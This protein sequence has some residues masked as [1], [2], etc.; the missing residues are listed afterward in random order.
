MAPT[1]TVKHTWILIPAALIALVG[2]LVVSV[3][4]TPPKTPPAPLGASATLDGGVARIHGVIPTETD[5]WEPST[6][7]AQLAQQPN[8]ELHRVR[9]LVELTALEKDG[10]SFE[11]SEYAVSALGADVWKP[12]WVSPE[13]ATAHQGQSIDAILVFELPNRAIDLT[14]ELPG[15]T[16]LSLG[17]GHHRGGN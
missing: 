15:G 4:L 10:L 9:V 14:L 13:S 3:L 1:T 2:T 6:P 17:P 12:V 11:P 5:G 7:S 8:D 16:G